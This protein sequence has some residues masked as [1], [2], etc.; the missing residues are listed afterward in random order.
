VDD[1]RQRLAGVRHHTGLGASLTL[2][3]ASPGV[4]VEQIVLD[5][6][7]SNSSGYSAAVAAQTLEVLGGVGNSPAAEYVDL[8]L[9]VVFVGEDGS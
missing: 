3:T 8:R 5:G 1:D 4:F 6:T 2:A 7:G 9:I